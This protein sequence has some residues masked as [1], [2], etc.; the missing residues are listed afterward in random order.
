MVEN[1]T[2]VT[3]NEYDVV[4]YG[5]TGFT[6]QFVA[7]QIVK[8]A[9]KNSGLKYAFAGRSKDK[10]DKT[11]ELAKSNTGLD[12]DAGII[13]A[14]ANDEESLVNMAKQARIIINCV[15][16]Y[17]YYGEKVVT[18]CL[19][20]GA[21][22][23]DISGEPQYLETMQLKYNEEAAEKNLYIV[24]ACGFDSI[25]ADLGTL[26]LQENFPGDLNSVEM[27]VGFDDSSVGSSSIN[28]TTLECAVLGL[29]HS[30]ELRAIRKELFPTSL[31]KPAFR[32]EPRGNLFYSE[33][34]KRWCLPNMASDRSVVLRT[35]RLNYELEKMRPVQFSA[36]FGMTSLLTAVGGVLFGIFFYVM[37]SFSFTRNLLLKY[38]EI[39]TFGIFSRK[40]PELSTL[41]GLKFCITL[42]GKGWDTKLEDPA[43]QH[44]DP[45][46]TTKTVTV[47]G[48]DPGYTACAIVV[49]QAALTILEE[50]DRLP[51]KGG[52]Y[53]PGAAFLKTSL[54]DRL[55][56]NNIKFSVQE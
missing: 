42:T 39:F 22:H 21:H 32:P 9:E 18:A 29:A 27:V 56:A 47:V 34:A 55:E 28:F 49:T 3:E 33:E 6:G 26:F 41:K 5:A 20:G 40:G 2:K 14:D 50:K 1:D 53:P 43:E 37:T 17:R 24:G 31:P 44:T 36:F 11:V 30:K 35:Q 13:I 51:V 4:V 19:K 38:P 7:E 52:V 16:P 23:V 10:L 54:R 46:N 15:G 48:P 12:V 8:V 45:P 25:P